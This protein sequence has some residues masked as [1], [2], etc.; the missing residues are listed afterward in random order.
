MKDQETGAEGTNKNKGGK[1]IGSREKREKKS[2][3]L[4]AEKDN[5][6]SRVKEVDGKERKKGIKTK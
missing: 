6:K 5:E 2:K 1:T 4:N 3:L